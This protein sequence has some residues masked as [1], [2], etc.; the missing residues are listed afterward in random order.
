[1]GRKQ[2]MNDLEKIQEILE[3]GRFY[4][5]L[6]NKEYLYVYPDKISDCVTI[7]VILSTFFLDNDKNVN[8]KIKVISNGVYATNF[9][10]TIYYSYNS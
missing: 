4:T 1:M 5:R 8:T 10:L 3:N 6:E 9:Y 2:K 7:G